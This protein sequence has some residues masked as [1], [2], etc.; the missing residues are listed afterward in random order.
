MLGD[1]DPFWGVP[2]SPLQDPTGQ[3][4]RMEAELPTWLP[5]S[6]SETSEES[7]AETPLESSEESSEDSPVESPW[8]GPLKA[9]PDSPLLSTQ[10]IPQLSPLPSPSHPSRRHPP[11][12]AWLMEEALWKQPRVVLTRLPLENPLKGP[13]E[14][15]LPSSSRPSQRHLPR[16]ARLTEKVLR[17]QPWVVLTRLLLPLGVNCRG[18]PGSGRP[19]GKWAKRPAP[20]R[21]A[22]AQETSLR[23]NIPPKRRK[24]VV[25]RVGEH[26]KT[27][28]EAKSDSDGVVTGSSR[29]QVG[30]SKR[31]APDGNNVPAKRARTL[32]DATG[33]SAARPP[34]R[35]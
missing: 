14:S 34:D 16:T 32:R 21:S 5:L 20:A 9:L 13:E 26:S 27:P 7:S 8:K 6:P 4:G 25:R 31:R 33:Q 11:R 28:R 10:G 24:M 23:D 22:K 1:T 17:R 29:Q 19:G 2:A 3:Q 30:S 12:T 15:P 35:F 18:V